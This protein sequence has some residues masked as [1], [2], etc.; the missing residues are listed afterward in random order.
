MIK[1]SIIETSKVAI[2]TKANSEKKSPAR[3][4]T[5]KKNEKAMIVVKTADNTAVMTSIVPSIA[6]LNGDFPFS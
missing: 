3:P 2:T 5:I 4:S 1:A 6:A